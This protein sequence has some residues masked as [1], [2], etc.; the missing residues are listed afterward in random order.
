M[1]PKALSLG[2]SVSAADFIRPNIF[3]S[4]VPKSNDLENYEKNTKTSK[5][6]LPIIIVPKP[7]NVP[8]TSTGVIPR[9]SWYK[10][11]E[12]VKT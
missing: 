11:P 5:Q 10:T 8:R 1:T 6:K 2:L 4:S 12:H 7:A 3:S 9:H